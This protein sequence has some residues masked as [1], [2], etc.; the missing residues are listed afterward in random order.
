M[1]IEL[2]A[3]SVLPRRARRR[4]RALFVRFRRS[5]KGTTLIEFAFVATP[6]LMLFLG[7]FEMG[8]LLWTNQVLEESLSQAARSLLTGQS[9][10]LYKGSAAA[11]ATAFRDAICANSTSFLDCSKITID[12]RR[13]ANF[14]A[15][16][17]GTSSSSPIKGGALD[18]SGFGYSQPQPGDIVV[19]RAAMEYTLYFSQWS[20]A[21]ANIGTGKRGLVA[22]TTFRAE[23]Y[24]SS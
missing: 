14:A 17:S 16:Q 23:P 3:S 24:T 9:T 10:S 20:Q 12:V 11:N 13:Y 4:L 6:F 19:V 7:I 8:L 18:T 2:S 1:R 21:L 22:S 5:Q 15:A